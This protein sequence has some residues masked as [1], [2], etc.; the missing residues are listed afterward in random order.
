MEGHE[1]DLAGMLRLVMWAIN[2]KELEVPSIFIGQQLGSSP[3]STSTRAGLTVNRCRQLGVES[4]EYGGH[5]IPSELFIVFHR[6]STFGQQSTGRKV[7]TFQEQTGNKKGKHL[8]RKHTVARRQ[9]LLWPN[10]VVELLLPV[11]S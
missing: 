3:G 11:L 8:C 10:Y 7:E 1:E 5:S 4:G 9:I 6:S 2:D